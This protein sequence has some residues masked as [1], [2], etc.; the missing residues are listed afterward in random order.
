[1]SRYLCRFASRSV[2]FLDYLP[3]Q[4]AA[5]SFMLSLNSIRSEPQTSCG[6]FDQ[7]DSEDLS[8]LDL[9]CSES[10]DDFSLLH[11]LDKESCLLTK[12]SDKI[13]ELTGLERAAQIKAP[14][15]KLIISLKGQG[16]QSGILADTTN[17]SALFPNC[18]GEKSCCVPSRKQSHQE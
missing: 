3:S 18:G 10:D 1:M 13:C 8:M 11:V 12:W 17:I 9:N 6:L 7:S 5:A 16:I 2:D 14:Y 15:C 4:I